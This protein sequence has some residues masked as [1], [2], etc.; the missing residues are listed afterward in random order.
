MSDV[1][2]VN[3][4]PLILLGKIARLDL[5]FRLAPRVVIPEGV[6]AE[7]RAGPSADAA[8]VWVE[9]VG[10]KAV[11]A[12]EQVDS[13]V[14]AWDLGLGES[15]V[16]TLCRSLPDG[17]AILDDRAARTCAKA[18]GVRVLGTVALLVLAKRKRVITEVKPLLE[19]LLDQ[20]IRLDAVVIETALRLAEERPH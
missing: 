13:V 9:G 8:R 16:L 20:G 5:L 14:A 6:A 3:A 17:T 18:L 4:S 7:L 12:V 19:N 2:V 1:W 15:H 10:A 11:T